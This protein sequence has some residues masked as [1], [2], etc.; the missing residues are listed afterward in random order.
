MT[1]ASD[2]YYQSSEAR[3]L[4]FDIQASLDNNVNGLAV[5]GR[6]TSVADKEE[7]KIQVL[8]EEASSGIFRR[9]KAPFKF[10]QEA[11]N[12][13]P[14]VCTLYGGQYLPC[15]IGVRE[16]RFSP[17]E[18]N[19]S[20]VQ[21][22][23][24]GASAIVE[25]LKFSPSEEYNLA[26]PVKIKE[27]D[28]FLNK[29]EFYNTFR[30]YIPNIAEDI[31]DN[32]NEHL[33]DKGSML[34]DTGVLFLYLLRFFIPLTAAY[35]GIH[36][37]AWNFEFPSRIESITWRTACF[38]IMGSSFALLAVP[39]WKALCYYMIPTVP[40]DSDQVVILR[41]LTRS[42]RILS[43]PRTLRFLRLSKRRLRYGFILLS[44]LCYATARI[45]L[46][47][48]SF[49]SLRHVPIGVYVAVPWVQNIPHV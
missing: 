10:N 16:D 1:I 9:R 18:L 4:F 20:D 23:E 30:E 41:H 26:D 31:V 6:E 19:S 36:L 39:S 44:F 11:V 48:E 43:I 25:I 13:K 17:C 14:T 8:G 2:V 5:S 27:L 21:R 12:P 22:W 49:I 15:G 3:T 29:H 33:L 34:K 7:K 46:V 24:L 28:E 37:T 45:Y 38:I 42:P 32:L 40:G 35:G 47:V